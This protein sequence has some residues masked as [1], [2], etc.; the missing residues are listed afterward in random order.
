M[1]FRDNK[2]LLRGLL[3]KNPMLF[4]IYSILSKFYFT[5][6]AASIV[7]TYF[8]FKGLDKA[9]LFQYSEKTLAKA[10]VDTKD[11]AKNCTPIIGKPKEFWNCLSNPSQYSNEDH[12]PNVNENLDEIIKHIEKIEEDH[13]ENPDPYQKKD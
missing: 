10:I 7:I 5:I 12:D 9:G 2:Y 4:F 6:I 13:L 8:V 11:I 1:F 3:K